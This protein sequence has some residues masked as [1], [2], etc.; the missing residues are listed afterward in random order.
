MPGLPE[1]AASE[2]QAQKMSILRNALISQPWLFFVG[3][4]I[5]Y[6]AIYE[7]VVYF[8]ADGRCSIRSVKEAIQNADVP[9]TPLDTGTWKLGECGKEWAVDCWNMQYLEVKFQF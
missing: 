9:P 5:R 4:D 8:H 3:P 2:A 6:H 7:K 1:A